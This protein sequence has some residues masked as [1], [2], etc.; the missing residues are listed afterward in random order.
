MFDAARAVARIEQVYG[1][2][3]GGTPVPDPRP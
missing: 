1:A 2:L 3:A